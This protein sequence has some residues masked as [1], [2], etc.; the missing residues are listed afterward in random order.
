M[1]HGAAGGIPPG[2]ETHVSAWVRKPFEMSEVLQVMGRLLAAP[3]PA[4]RELADRT[5]LAGRA[6]RLYRVGPDG[7]K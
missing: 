6:T 7:R 5:L 2:V 1:A 4:A 3:R